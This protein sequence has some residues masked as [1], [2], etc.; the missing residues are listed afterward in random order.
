ML[1]EAWYQMSITSSDYRAFDFY[2]GMALLLLAIIPACIFIFKFE[3]TKLKRFWWFLLIA[4]IFVGGVTNS[5][6]RRSNVFPLVGLNEFDTSIRW[7]IVYTILCLP[8]FYFIYSGKNRLL[9]I[10]STSFI[11]GIMVLIFIFAGLRWAENLIEISALKSQQK[12]YVE[13]NKAI[14]KIIYPILIEGNELKKVKIYDGNHSNN[15]PLGHL[16]RSSYP[17][18]TIWRDGIS[19]KLPH[20]LGKYFLTEADTNIFYNKYVKKKNFDPAG[21]EELVGNLFNTTFE[22]LKFLMDTPLNGLGSR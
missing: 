13:E 4:L 11:S 12:E 22:S 3:K 9:K 21:K 6:Y 2:E 15:A 18:L 8:F 5:Y 17:K 16:N 1:A 10:A 20:F 19:K 14:K 7:W